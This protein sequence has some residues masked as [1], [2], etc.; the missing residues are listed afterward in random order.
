MRLEGSGKDEDRRGSQE[1][2]F[3]AHLV[4]PVNREDL[5]VLPNQPDPMAPGR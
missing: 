3:N 4:K 1:A 5:Q 2:G